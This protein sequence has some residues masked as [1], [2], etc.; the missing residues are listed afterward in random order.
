MYFVLFLSMSL[1]NI[2]Q[3][4]KGYGVAEYQRKQSAE[5]PADADEFQTKKR[6][7]IPSENVCLF[8][9]GKQMAVAGVHVC[10]Q[11][12]V[13]FSRENSLQALNLTDSS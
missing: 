2:G 12:T 8:H 4:K 3:E 13:L 1:L 10:L 5:G 9:S 6:C 7:M 11:Y